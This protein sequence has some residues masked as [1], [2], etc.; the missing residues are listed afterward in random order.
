M[1]L[2][3]K[4]LI[5]QRASVGAKNAQ[6]VSEGVTLYFQLPSCLLPCQAGE[7]LIGFHRFEILKLFYHFKHERSS[8]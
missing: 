3:D 6:N 4:K 5:V 2:G 8:P 7:R 1:Q